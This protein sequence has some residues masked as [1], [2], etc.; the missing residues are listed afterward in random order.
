MEA[1]RTATA[2]VSGMHVCVLR[3]D[4][5]VED[6][7]VCIES[8]RSG[9]RI[10]FSNKTVHVPAVIPGLASHMV[11]FRVVIEPACRAEVGGGVEMAHSGTAASP[12]LGDPQQPQWL[13]S[14]FYF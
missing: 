6:I 14:S 5:S 12:L 7:S 3:Q 1:N 9:T 11:L 2:S 8:L 13:L 10:W 4:T